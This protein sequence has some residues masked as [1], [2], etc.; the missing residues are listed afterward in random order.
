MSESQTES[1]KKPQKIR[2]ICTYRVNSPLTLTATGQYIPA[3]VI[4]DL[5]DCD[6]GFLHWALK[7]GTIETADPSDAEPLY[8]VAT[9]KVKRRP[10]PQCN[11]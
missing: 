1:Q 9:G 8:N 6:D 4:A 3:G 10:C 7:N 5:G 2:K 11:Q